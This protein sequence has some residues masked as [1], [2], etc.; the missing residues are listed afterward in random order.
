MEG[1]S[2]GSLSF[3]D[4]LIEKSQN[5][6][7]TKVYRKSSNS[8]LNTSYFSFCPFKFKITS[9]YSLLSRA[10]GIC[11]NFNLLN[12]EFNVI[13]RIFHLNGY[14]KNII[15]TTIGNFLSKKMKPTPQVA[16]PIQIIYLS[17]PYFGYQSEK[18]R[19]ELSILM[20]NYF[21]NISF[22]FILTNP[23]KISKF[24]SYKDKI[25]KS[26]RSTLIYKFSCVHC[27]SEYVGSTTRTLGM[28]VA[29]HAG[30]SFRTNNILSNR[31]N[32]NIYDHANQCNTEINLDNFTI[33]NS[34]SNKTDLHIL[35]SL[36]IYKT[37]PL[38]N[39]SQTAYPL[40]IVNK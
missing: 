18:L 38:L 34:C 25:P 20:Y 3:L 9:L 16:S 6:F 1:E 33:L 36:Y 27:T 2:S 13:R 28:R 32:S 19:R 26:M 5:R 4:V 37:K 30:R 24:F 12:T 8:D 31:P 29:E 21:N 40:S 11:T 39:S 10:Y 22:R 23:Y 7:L 17:L 35:E 15:D 14:S